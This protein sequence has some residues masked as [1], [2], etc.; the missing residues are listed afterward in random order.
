MLS[1][2]PTSRSLRP[3]YSET[4]PFPLR[5][6]D[7]VEP[8]AYFDTGAVPGGGEPLLFIHGLGGNFTHWEN[9]ATRLA[10]T[11]RVIG[12]DLP[13]CGDSYRLRLEAGRRYSIRLFADAT[14]RLLDHLHIE[15]AVYAGH[16]MGGMVVT[17]AALRHERRVAGL[18]LIDSAGFHRYP[19]WMLGAGARILKPKLVSRVMERMALRLLHSCF[20]EEN[21]HAKRFIA[22][23]EGR[24]PHPTLDEFAETACSLLPDLAGTHYLD[25]VE[26][27]LQPTLVIWGDRDRLVAFAEVPAW[28]KRLRE[29]K[30]VVIKGCGHMPIIERP[31]ETHVAILDFLAVGNEWQLAR[32]G[33]AASA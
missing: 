12:I 20:H 13:G 22:Q 23:A 6:T 14:V 18:V 1:F 2:H 29:G 27:I 32:T 5:Y 11:H 7:G 33:T 15:S 28:A 26:R 10:R 3:G 4:F 24:P 8:I 19:R 9:L 30:L 31:E 21:D 16:S 25:D 17:E